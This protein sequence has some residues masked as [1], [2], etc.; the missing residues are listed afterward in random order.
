MNLG[1]MAMNGIEVFSVLILLSPMLGVGIWTFLG[2]VAAF[3]PKIINVILI[4]TEMFIKTFTDKFCTW[5]DNG[6]RLKI[7]IMAQ[8]LI[9]FFGEHVRSAMIVATLP[10]ESVPTQSIFEPIKQEL[11]GFE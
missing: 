8:D 6:G 2:G 1:T 10:H 9:T 7:Q 4:V 3:A 11:V 5:F